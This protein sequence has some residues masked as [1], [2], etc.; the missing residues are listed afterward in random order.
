MGLSMEKKYK[1]LL[2]NSIIFAISNF[3]T[4]VI[5]FCLVPLYTLYMSSEEYGIA[6]LIILLSY[7]ITSISSISIQDAILRF[8]LQKDINQN[9][10]IRCGVFVWSFSTILIV[11]L[12]L[13]VSFYKPIHPWRWYLAAYSIVFVLFHM[14][15]NYSRVVNRVKL[16]AVASISQSLILAVF[17]FCFLAV[18]NRSIQGYLISMIISFLAADAFMFWRLHLL[19]IVQTTSFN[20]GLLQEMVVFSAPMVVNSISWQIIHVSDKIMIELMINASILGLYTAASKIPSLINVVSTI[21]QQAWG[22]SS[23]KEKESSNDNAFYAN[24]FNIYSTLMFFV[25]IVIV[26][27]SKPFMHFYIRNPEY[28]SV[29]RFVPLLLV[30]ATFCAIA[31]YYTGIYSALKLTVNSMMSTL[32]GSIVNVFVNYLFISKLGI[33]GALIGTLAAY[34]FIAQYRIIDVDKYIRI[35]FD[36]KRYYL[37]A[38]IVLVQAVLVSLEYQITVVSICSVILFAML[39][40]PLFSSIAIRLAS[41][42]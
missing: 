25:C 30:S 13:L 41:R 35:G 1:E 38:L 18:F 40:I 2:N 36:K 34:M 23:I 19:R 16:F 24:V 7:L 8:G 32:F 15:L 22:I 14:L 42:K 17:S 4:K 6:E 3:G 28:S 11:M 10:V 33:W 21:F 31:M 26:A 9:Q 12:S 37:N 39:N 27:I 29:W 5:Q 20:K